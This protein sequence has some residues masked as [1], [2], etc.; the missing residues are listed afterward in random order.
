MA[1]TASRAGLGAM[2]RGCTQ[3]WFWAYFKLV[4]VQQQEGFTM[5]VMCLLSAVVSS[6]PSYLAIAASLKI[7]QL[8]GCC[9]YELGRLASCTSAAHKAELLHNRCQLRCDFS[10]DD[11]AVLQSALQLA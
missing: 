8:A 4:F 7:S 1:T 3:V 6:K 2:A 9:S 10:T 11:M 5:P